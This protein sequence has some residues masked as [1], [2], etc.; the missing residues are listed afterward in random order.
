M[1]EGDLVPIA[2][3]SMILAALLPPAAQHLASALWT[4]GQVKRM[5]RP[6]TKL[7]ANVFYYET[8]GRLRL[9]LEQ[10]VAAFNFARG[11][12]TLKGHT[13]LMSS[14][15]IFWAPFRRSLIISG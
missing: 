5:K 3:E 10:F 2:A 8:Y 4:N 6:S 12:K 7:L 11:F 1:P 14:S 15:H 13:A 9:K